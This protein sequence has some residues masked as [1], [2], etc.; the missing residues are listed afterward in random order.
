MCTVQISEED[1]SV[2]SDEEVLAPTLNAALDAWFQD[3]EP[4]KK[5]VRI[6]LFSK[7]G[8]AALKVYQEGKD[9]IIVL[10]SICVDEEFQRQGIATN[11]LKYVDAYFSTRTPSIK[12]FKVESVLNEYM[13]AV[14]IKAGLRTMSDY[15]N[16][17]Y[18]YFTG[19]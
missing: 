5:G 8:E 13:A 18:K 4:L 7:Q 15:S 19:K 3:P 6:E 2:E 14:C 16:D 9:L 17:F 10:E 1:W 12:G 11:F